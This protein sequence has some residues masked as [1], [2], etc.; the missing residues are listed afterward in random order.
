MANFEKEILVEDHFIGRNLCF[1][2][3][4]K[5]MQEVGFEIASEIHHPAA[6]RM[7]TLVRPIQ[8]IDL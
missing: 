8:S 7:I 3:M 4:L 6:G 1:E 5:E 2:T